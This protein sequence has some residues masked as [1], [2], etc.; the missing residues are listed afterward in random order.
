MTTERHPRARGSG[1]T[2][3]NAPVARTFREA[4]AIADPIERRA[5]F[6]D[7]MW[8]TYEAARDR[9]YV[10]KRGERIPNPDGSTV[11]KVLALMV[12]TASE[13]PELEQ[14]Y[15]DA[16]ARLV[17]ALE[18]LPALAAVADVVAQKR[19]LLSVLK[20]AAIV[21]ALKPNAD[22]NAAVGTFRVVAQV[23]GVGKDDD[24]MSEAELQE[25]ARKLLEEKKQ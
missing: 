20:D 5:W 16:K 6:A 14:R 12:A 4:L 2:P 18:Q 17:D 9:H 15:R 3:A 24:D 7:R 8:E 25:M 11:T 21:A 22:V 10:N 23:L 1:R 19:A 13:A